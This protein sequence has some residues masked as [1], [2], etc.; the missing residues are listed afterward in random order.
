[1]RLLASYAFVLFPRALGCEGF[2]TTGGAELRHLRRLTKPSDTNAKENYVSILL[3]EL[4][5]IA[6]E[7]IWT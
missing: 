6:E 7:N 3:R 5:N 2:R 4:E 1:M